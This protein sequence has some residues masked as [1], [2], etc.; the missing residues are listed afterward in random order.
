[1]NCVNAALKHTLELSRVS[2][3]KTQETIGN[4]VQLILPH[5]HHVPHMINFITTI[6]RDG[7]N[8]MEPFLP[9]LV[10]LGT[11]SFLI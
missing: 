11:G 5:V 9:S 7:R 3:G 10:L 1:M 2:K 8:E 4:D 6:A